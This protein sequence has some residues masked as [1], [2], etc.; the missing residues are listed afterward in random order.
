MPKP[1]PGFPPEA[2]RFLSQLSRN[3]N[4]DWFTPRKERF[5]EFVRQPMLDL[6]A[7]IADD[8]R[9]FAADHV[10]PPNKA[11]YRIYRDTRFSKDKTPYKTHLAAIFPPKGFEKHMA[12]GYY[13][14]VSPTAVEIAGGLYGPGPAE[15]AAIRNGIA[16][17]P[18]RWLKLVEDK[19]I[20]KKLGRLYGDQLTRV[21][22]GFAADHPAADYLRMKQWFFD[23]TLPP[24]AATLPTF[25]RTIIQHFKAMTPLITWINSVLTAARREEEGDVDDIPRRPEPMF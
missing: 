16:K 3:N 7:R 4:R 10:V 2:L 1:F 21:P 23:V 6:V 18:K 24:K 13:F 14:H 19:A 9:S 12:G 11:V 5:E 15:L 22:K 8:L 20:V 17:D 25:Q